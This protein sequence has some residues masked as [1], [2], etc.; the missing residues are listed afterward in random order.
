[1]TVFIS[2]PPV[3][4][5][6]LIYLPV[7]VIEGSAVGPFILTFISL[8]IEADMELATA[9]RI[10]ESLNKFGFCFTMNWDKVSTFCYTFLFSLIP[11]RS[12]LIESVSD[13]IEPVQDITWHCNGFYFITELVRNEEGNFIADIVWKSGLCKFII[14][15]C[16][17]EISVDCMLI[18]IF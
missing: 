8:V 14:A 13:L 7:V 6:W 3:P 1:M 15:W 12:L 17:C 18:C 2:T 11:S 9:I 16:V 4:I 10:N 5:I